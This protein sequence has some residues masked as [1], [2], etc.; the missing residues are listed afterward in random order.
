MG[1]AALVTAG[2]GSLGKAVAI[3]LQA[4]GH[5]VALVDRCDAIT[6]LAFTQATSIPVFTWDIADVAA[7]SKGIAAVERAIGSIDILVNY[8]GAGH[9]AQWEQTIHASLSA[10]RNMSR[11]IIDGMRLRGFGRIVNIG[12]VSVL[13]GAPGQRDHLAAK[14]DILA[15][16]ETLAL[17]V[18]DKQVTV[19][20]IAAGY[21]TETDPAPGPCAAPEERQAGTPVAGTPVARAGTPHDISRAVVFL[22]DDDAGFITG[23]VIDVDGGRHLAPNL[24]TNLATSESAAQA[25]S[26]LDWSPQMAL[27]VAEIDA[28]HRALIAQLAQARSAPDAAFENA[29][30]ALIVAL[31]SDFREEE[32]LMEAIDFPGIRLHREQHARVLAALH[33][34]VP[35]VMQGDHAQARKA[36]ELIPSWFMLH[37][38]TMDATLAVAL[39]LAAIPTDPAQAKDN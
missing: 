8:V 17:T 29:L 5:R 18:A 11:S 13:P 16:T 35:Q 7:C 32:T 3:A 19:N 28:S 24:A 6:A 30:Q 2:T 15:L 25:D 4:R 37:L 23:T 22:V 31:E 20:A 27:G 14:A 9:E 33:Q 38:T 1:R 39:E 12:P 34:V 21:G 26:A 36:V 10:M